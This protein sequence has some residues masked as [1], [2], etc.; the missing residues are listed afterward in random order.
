MILGCLPWRKKRRCLRGRGWTVDDV[1]ETCEWTK[2]CSASGGLVPSSLRGSRSY[3]KLRLSLLANVW[4]G[5]IAMLAPDTVLAQQG[6]FLYVP[7]ASDNNVSVLDTATNSTL[8][9]TIPVGSSPFAAGVRADQALVYVTNLISNN[10]S[11]IDTGT[12]SVVATVGVGVNPFLAAVSPNG[13]FV[14]VSNNGGSSVSVINAATNTVSATVTVGAA[15][16]G[17]A[18]TPDGTRVYVANF[19]S[20]TVSVIDTATNTVIGAPIPVGNSPTGMAIAPDGSRAYV[21]NTNSNSISVINTATN[22]VIGAPIAV[23]SNPDAV[24]VSPNGTR[25]YVTNF[26]SNTVSVIDAAANTVVATIPVGNA[27][28]KIA[29]QPATAP[30]AAAPAAVMPAEGQKGTKSVS[31]AGVAYTDHGTL[32]ISAQR[33]VKLEADDYYFG[34]TFLRGK[35]GQRLRLRIENESGTLHNITIADQQIDRDILSK[36][37]IE[38]DVTMP[39]SGTL[40]FS[41]KFHGPLGMN[42]HL[43]TTMP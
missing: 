2:G 24:A 36:K 16:A 38:V 35:P 33:V 22:T 41:C 32:D 42:G 10:V 21:T 26:I 30:R 31:I 8:P 7:N 6:P 17:L 3:S 34:P 1:L 12:N 18:I 25:I 43:A 11:V 5:S 27:P 20:N 37:T 9:P 4:L 13:A 29:V 39:A 19:S 23:G 28:R 15:P 14:Y 40:V